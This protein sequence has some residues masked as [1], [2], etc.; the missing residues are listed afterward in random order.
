MIIPTIEIVQVPATEP[1]SVNL[2]IGVALGVVPVEH[3]Q[4]VV[5]THDG[6]RQDPE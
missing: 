6:F 5:V 3:K 1:A 2:V 4:L